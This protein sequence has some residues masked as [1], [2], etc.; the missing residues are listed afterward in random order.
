MSALLDILGTGHPPNNAGWNMDIQYDER[1]M[2]G[3]SLAVFIGARASDVTRKAGDTLAED[4]K[5]VVPFMPDR[6]LSFDPETSRAIAF[7]NTGLEGQ[8]SIAQALRDHP[9]WVV[10]FLGPHP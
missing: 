10:I 4:L 2:G 8:K 5:Q 3:M 9:D 6:A 7:R 1:C